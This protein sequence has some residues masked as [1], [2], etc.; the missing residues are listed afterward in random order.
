[1]SFNQRYYKWQKQCLKIMN[2]KRKEK[3]KKLM[4]CVAIIHEM[5]RT[6]KRKYRK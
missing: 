1:M 5:E 6:Q 4:I 2:L 3:N